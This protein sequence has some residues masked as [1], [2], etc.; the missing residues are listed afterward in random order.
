ML[1]GTFLKCEVG[2]TY[3]NPKWCLCHVCFNICE[4]IQRWRELFVGAKQT[5]EL[6]ESEFQKRKNDKAL[7][8]TNGGK[9]R[10]LTVVS[11][12]I[13]RKQL[14]EIVKQK[15]IASVSSK[16]EQQCLMGNSQV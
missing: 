12:G 1:L 15:A 16:I 13:D 9:I 4:R 10:E 7:L 5:L 2:V 11:E 6:A 3:V 8:Y 14:E